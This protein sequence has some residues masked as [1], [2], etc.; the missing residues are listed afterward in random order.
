[1]YA[2]NRSPILPDELL[3]D[4]MRAQLAARQYRFSSLVETIVTSPPFLN[5]RRADAG[6]L[7]ART[8]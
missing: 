5:R 4:K 8:E 6:A 7:H 3:L 2:L 1:V